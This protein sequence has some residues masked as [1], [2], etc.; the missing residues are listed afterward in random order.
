MNGKKKFFKMPIR[1]NP[2]LTASAEVMTE[3]SPRCHEHHS[4]FSMDK[5]QT[6]AFNSKLKSGHI[7]LSKEKKGMTD[8]QRVGSTIHNKQKS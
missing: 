1:D 3:N 5:C 6:E 7:F 2:S 8:W 4:F